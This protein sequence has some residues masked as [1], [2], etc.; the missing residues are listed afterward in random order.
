MECD[1]LLYLEERAEVAANYHRVL[2]SLQR[3]SV[4]IPHSVTELQ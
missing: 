4:H 1:H 3:T 2:Y